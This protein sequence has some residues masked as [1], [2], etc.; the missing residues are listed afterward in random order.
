LG[1][2]KR[3]QQHYFQGSRMSQD[4]YL[5]NGKMSVYADSGYL[6]MIVKDELKSPI[7]YNVHPR[8]LQMI[9]QVRVGDLA[10]TSQRDIGLI[11]EEVDRD[12]QGFTM[13]KVLIK[14]EEQI[15]SSLELAL[16]GE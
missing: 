2:T 6:N 15:F 4:I 8:H 3:L 14:G 7:T 10:E 11:V 16:I 12:L 13:Y 9:E 1:D 5:P